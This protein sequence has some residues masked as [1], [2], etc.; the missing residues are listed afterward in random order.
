MHVVLISKLQAPQIAELSA[1]DPRIT[2]T[3]ASTL[4]VPE[5]VADWPAHTI[6]GYLRIPASGTPDGPDQARQREALL[7]D[8]D[9]LGI[10]FPYPKRLASRAPKLRFVHQFPAGVSNLV[11]S[12]LWDG[13]V[14]VTSG[15]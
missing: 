9:V 2:V 1:I 14:P 11:G 7:A 6:A 4:F 3:D 10:A 8:A 5:I 12:D 13:P 15:R